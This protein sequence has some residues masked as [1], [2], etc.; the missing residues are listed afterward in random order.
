MEL[1]EIII[2]VQAME[3]RKII[4]QS[5]SYDLTESCLLTFLNRNNVVMAASTNIGKTK[6]ATKK[7]KNS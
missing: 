4:I 1:T 2:K 3:L 5:S 6:R 7:D